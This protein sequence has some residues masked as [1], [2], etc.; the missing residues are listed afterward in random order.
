MG[1]FVDGIWFT[2]SISVCSSGI[3]LTHMHPGQTSGQSPTTF[4]FLIILFFIE[5]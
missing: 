2:M 3:G 1:N 5:V 4:F